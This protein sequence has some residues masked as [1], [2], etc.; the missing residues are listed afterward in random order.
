MILRKTALPAPAAVAG[1]H[2]PVLPA[3]APAHSHAAPAVAA[4]IWMATA[5]ILPV[6]SAAAMAKTIVR[7][8]AAV[9][10]SIAAAVVAVGG[11]EAGVEADLF[12]LFLKR[13]IQQ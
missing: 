1:V 10:T 2:F 8:A 4:G 9:V 12:L 3:V 7:V 11:S 5:L 13:F 6:P